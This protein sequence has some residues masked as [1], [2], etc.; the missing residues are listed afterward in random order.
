MTAA[1]INEGGAPVT[2]LNGVVKSD[3]LAEFTVSGGLYF[4]LPL[5]KRLSLG[6]KFLVGRSF[7]QELDID[8]YAKG[9]VKDID[10]GMVIEKGDV[11]YL[12]I[13]NPV[14]TGEQYTDEWDY[15]K[16]GSNSAT[17]WGTGISVTYRYKSNFSWR[18]YCDYD[19]AKK[20]YTLTNDNYHF[21]KAGLT[22]DAYTLVSNRDVSALAYLMDPW[23]F[24]KEKEMHYVTVGLSFLV[25]F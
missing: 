6:T 15:I 24:K 22:R 19:Y 8:G 11:T 20:T 13:D 14:S 7:T 17:S 16:L 2:E 3:H 4:N 12:A 9:H 18:L 25:N 21:L 10:Y 1:I 5:T 23:V